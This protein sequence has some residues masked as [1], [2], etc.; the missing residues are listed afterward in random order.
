[1]LLQELQQSPDSAKDEDNNDITQEH[2]TGEGEYQCPEKQTRLLTKFV[3][4][5]ICLVA[6]K[7]FN[8]LPT[9]EV[10]GS[11]VNIEQ[12]PSENFLQFLDRLRTQV[13]RQVPDPMI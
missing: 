13:E 5:K 3:L 6:E 1:M 9:V 11:Y 2:L 12:F 8:Q 7:A 10:K 4:D